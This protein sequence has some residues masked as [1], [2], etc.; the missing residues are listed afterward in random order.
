MKAK[1]SIL[2]GAFFF[3]LFN[4]F[5]DGSGDVTKAVG[6]SENMAVI[7]N[8]D[9][10]NTW[11]TAGS[12]EQERRQGFRTA[13]IYAKVGKPIPVSKKLAAQLAKLLDEIGRAH[14]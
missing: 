9:S 4:C 12:L 2:L 8:P 5:G 13:D 7:L 10:V 3:I 14:V 6:G 11:R 1:V